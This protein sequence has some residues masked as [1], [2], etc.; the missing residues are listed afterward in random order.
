MRADRA[1]HPKLKADAPEFYP[2]HL[3]GETEGTDGSVIGEYKQQAKDRARQGK[4]NGRQE[5]KGQRS[6][7]SLAKTAAENAG[8]QSRQLSG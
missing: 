1:E 2:R 8:K 3:R 4:T 5:E 6:H 7:I